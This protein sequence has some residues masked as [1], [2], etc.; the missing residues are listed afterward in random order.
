VCDVCAIQGHI[1]SECQLGHS[2]ENVIVQQADALYNF[3]N[4]SQNDP[5]SNTF[6]SGWRD[7][8]NFSYKNPILF[9]TLLHKITLIH[10]NSNILPPLLTSSTLS[11]KVQ[12]EEFDRTLHPN[13]SQ[14]H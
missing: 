12:L 7:Y 6:N 8:P 11:P 4:R 10:R 13:S 9:L 2:F 3:N 1:G 14:N 5:Y